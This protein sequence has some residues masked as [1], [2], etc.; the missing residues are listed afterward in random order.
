MSKHDKYILAVIVAILYVIAFALQN[1]I[2]AVAIV[3]LLWFFIA[4]SE[5]D[6]P[7]INDKPIDTM[8]Q[9][10]PLEIENGNGLHD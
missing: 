2:V 1:V 10:E 4:V 8:P 9:Y 7:K 3:L 6:A 5:P